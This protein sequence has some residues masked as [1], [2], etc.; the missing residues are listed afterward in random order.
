M[1]LRERLIEEIKHLS[2]TE[3]M[4]VKQVIDAIRYSPSQPAAGEGHLQTRRALAALKTE[5]AEE[6]LKAREERL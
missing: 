2:P 6:I 4:T 3:L 5:L 1:S